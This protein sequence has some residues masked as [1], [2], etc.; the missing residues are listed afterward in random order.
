MRVGT[1]T[2]SDGMVM[3]V[4]VTMVS[5]MRCVVAVIGVV[6]MVMVVVMRHRRS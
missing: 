2:H 3:M 5:G 4:V 1:A 6:V